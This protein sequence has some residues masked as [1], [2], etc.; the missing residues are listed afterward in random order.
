MGVTKCENCGGR[1]TNPQ[2]DTAHCVDCGH[3]TKIGESLA[4]DAAG[5]VTGL[6]DG[7][8]DKPKRRT[9]KGA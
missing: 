5:A 3:L 4:V 1:N 8:K 9:K 7:E 6:D 2:A